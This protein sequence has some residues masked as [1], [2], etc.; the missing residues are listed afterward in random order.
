MID[1]LGLFKFSTISDWVKE[2]F[3]T[4]VTDFLGQAFSFDFLSGFTFDWT[5][6]GEVIE[7]GYDDY[8]KP[9]LKLL[10]PLADMFGIK[11]FDIPEDLI[12]LPEMTMDINGNVVFD[13][14]TLAEQWDK[15]I[16]ENPIEMKVNYSLWDMSPE[17]EASREADSN[18]G[19]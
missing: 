7:K 11:E 6:I 2:K 13:A 19:G 12:K 4:P 15:F 18:T 9:A 16:S 14:Q 3:I 10:E 17:A 5:F 8:I 1:F